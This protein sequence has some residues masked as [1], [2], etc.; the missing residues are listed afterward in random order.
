AVDVDPTIAP[1]ETIRFSASVN[2]AV[3]IFIIN[4]F[5]AVFFICLGVASAISLFDRR[6]CNQPLRSTPLQSPSPSAPSSSSSSTAP[7]PSSSSAS[8]SPLQSASSID[9]S[10][11]SLFDRRLCNQPL[12]SASAIILRPALEMDAESDDYYHLPLPFPSFSQSTSSSSTS[13]W[14]CN[15]QR[16]TSGAGVGAGHTRNQ[17]NETLA[18][19]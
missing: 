9:A 3:V 4:G 10:S 8:A 11:I 14:I 13:T 16:I 17:Q 7:S 15:V 2:S 18:R 12:Q 19:F 1:S 5:I 6:L